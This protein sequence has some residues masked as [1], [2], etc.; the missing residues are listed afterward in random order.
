M[1]PDLMALLKCRGY[2][3]LNGWEMS[4][5]ANVERQVAQICGLQYVEI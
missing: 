5:G 1:I 4:R 3:L 2:T